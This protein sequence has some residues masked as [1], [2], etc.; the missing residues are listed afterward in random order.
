MNTQNILNTYLAKAPVKES[1][2]PIPGVPR[3]MVRIA[4][5]SSEWSGKHTHFRDAR[6]RWHLG[7]GRGKYPREDMKHW[8][9]SSFACIHGVSDKWILD[10]NGKGRR[11]KA[12][13]DDFK[14]NATR[15]DEIFL[16]CNAL[17]QWCGTYTGVTEDS[18][19][20]D[21]PGNTQARAN[22]QERDD[23]GSF[24]IHVDEWRKIDTPFKGTGAQHTL[25]EV[26]DNETYSSTHNV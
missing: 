4:D 17:V 21:A 2:D 7:C 5:T 11:R 16:H 23:G 8:V 13:F 18:S 6:K 10:N 12:L 1:D 25:Y 14:K 19:P 26:T 3:N 20:S 15:G 24:K 22:W 9:A